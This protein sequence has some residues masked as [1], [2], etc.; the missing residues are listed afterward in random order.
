MSSVLPDSSV[1]DLTPLQ[2][3]IARRA[4]QLA[5][6]LVPDRTTDLLI[7]LKAESDVLAQTDSASHKEVLV[8]Q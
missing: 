6:S 8:V 7:W 5:S 4:D 3:A 1:V 2:L